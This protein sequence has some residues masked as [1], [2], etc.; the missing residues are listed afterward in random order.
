MN[1][2]FHN[3]TAKNSF[4]K[5]SFKQKKATFAI[6]LFPIQNIPDE[7]HYLCRKQVGSPLTEAKNR[8]LLLDCTSRDGRKMLDAGV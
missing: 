3:L 8:D 5:L 4:L 2:Q 7:G 6:V 1:L